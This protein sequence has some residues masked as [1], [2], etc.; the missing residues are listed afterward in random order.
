MRKNLCF[1]I[2][3]KVGYVA[4]GTH[5]VRQL[6]TLLCLNLDIFSR[7]KNVSCH[8]KPVSNNTQDLPI[9]EGMGSI[10]NVRTCIRIFI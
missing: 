3:V 7:V 10:S 4:A 1:G 9:S 2:L 5:I 6:I 8:L